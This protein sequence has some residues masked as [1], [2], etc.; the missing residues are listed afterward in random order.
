MASSI[1]KSSNNSAHHSDPFTSRHSEEAK[2]PKNL[3]QGKLREE[4]TDPSVTQDALRINHASCYLAPQIMKIGKLKHITLYPPP[5]N[6]LPLGEG[7]HVFLSPSMGE[8]QGEGVGV[9]SVF[10]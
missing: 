2:R 6:S 8:G 4:S 10:L 5:S 7:G 9:L 1:A 3:A